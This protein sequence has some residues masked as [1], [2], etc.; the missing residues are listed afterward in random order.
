MKIV[1]NENVRP[2]DIDGCLVYPNA[3]GTEDMPGIQ[4]YDAVDKCFIHLKYNP[5]TVRLLKE[6]PRG[7][8]AQSSGLAQS[9]PYER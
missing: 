5:N 8:C 7:A 6:E 3:L 4:V 9:N 2:F 1:K